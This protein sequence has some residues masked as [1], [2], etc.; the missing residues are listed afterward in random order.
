[1]DKR[2]IEGI[3]EFSKKNKSNICFGLGL[4]SIESTI[5]LT[6]LAVNKARTKLDS[7]Q[8]EEKDTK[9]KKLKRIWLYFIPVII[10]NAVGVL[11]LSTS[12]KEDSKK[13]L[14]LTE[15]VSL[16][17]SLTKDYRDALKAADETKE[18]VKEVDRKS[19]EKLV[20][21]FSNPEAG[22]LVDFYEPLSKQWFKMS[23]EEYYRRLTNLYM[24][25]EDRID[26]TYL[27]EYFDIDTDEDLLD[28]FQDHFWEHRDFGVRLELKEK[29]S[30]TGTK[31]GYAMRY[32]SELIGYDRFSYML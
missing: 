28:E 19:D 9:L 18:L 24:D 23:M 6:I 31:P 30:K 16:A 20:K 13:I 2:I 15:A 21:T 8:D 7:L 11:L 25:F 10:L 12:H 29:T 5:A 32:D 27:F 4:I 14:E 26:V 22:E 1:M 17:T 3:L